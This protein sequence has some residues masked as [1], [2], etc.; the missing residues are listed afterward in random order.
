M[1]KCDA[2]EEFG[3]LENP[4]S[5]VIIDGGGTVECLA[6]HPTA[7]QIVAGASNMVLA[8][9]DVEAEKCAIGNCFYF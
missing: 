3:M 9:V 4:A 8:V 2:G 7:S 6:T 1:W 5:S